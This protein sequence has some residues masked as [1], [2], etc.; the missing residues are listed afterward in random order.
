VATERAPET[1]PNGAVPAQRPADEDARAQA[2]D[3]P[4]TQ[5]ADR[6]PDQARAPRGD[7][8]PSTAGLR[9]MVTGLNAIVWERDPDTLRIRFI[10]SR[11][12]EL[13][14]YPTEQWL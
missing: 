5:L 11:A 10:N 12:E 13:L 6:D 4:D 2:A 1:P 9:P 7:A 8:E 3:V 14:G